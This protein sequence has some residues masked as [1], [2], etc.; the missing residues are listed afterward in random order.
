MDENAVIISEF[1]ITITVQSKFTC[2]DQ[3]AQLLPFSHV[4]LGSESRDFSNRH[5]VL[6]VVHE[7]VC[8]CTVNANVC[9]A[10]TK[11]FTD[12]RGVH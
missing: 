2:S 12:I 8:L 9:L 11:R 4:I 5:D 10:G 3:L 1:S 7:I 6:P